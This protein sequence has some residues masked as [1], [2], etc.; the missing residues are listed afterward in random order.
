M[1]VANALPQP[2]DEQ[3]YA[4]P[5]LTRLGTL[6][7]L[8]LNFCIVDKQLGGSDGYTFMGMNVPISSCSS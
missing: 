6:H 3:A 1:R 4:P 2:V 5:T 8:T 7:E